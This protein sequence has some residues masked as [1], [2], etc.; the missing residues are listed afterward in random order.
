MRR[1][2]KVNERRNK[3]DLSEMEIAQQESEL[4]AKP[5]KK[6]K[7]ETHVASTENSKA[8]KKESKVQKKSLTEELECFENEQIN[9]SQTN[10]N[11]DGEKE[12][13]MQK[14]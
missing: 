10:N 2:S 12:E 14:Q 5:E 11:L 1:K 9:H 7:A 13:A 4:E 6:K 8:K 3:E